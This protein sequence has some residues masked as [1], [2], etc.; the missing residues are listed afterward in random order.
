MEQTKSEKSGGLEASMK[1]RR[2]KRHFNPRSATKARRKVLAILNFSIF[3][4][5]LEAQARGQTTELL[6]TPGSPVMFSPCCVFSLD[7]MA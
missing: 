5:M 3:Q 7:D 2:R 6:L 1:Q 4:K